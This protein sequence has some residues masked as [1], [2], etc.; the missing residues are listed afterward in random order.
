MIL[1]VDLGLLWTFLIFCN[2]LLKKQNY[3]ILACFAKS[4][5]DKF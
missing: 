2:L 5:V 3:Y 1:K 4:K